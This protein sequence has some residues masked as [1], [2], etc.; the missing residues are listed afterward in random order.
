MALW[1]IDGAHAQ[2]NFSARH[3]MVTT[4]RGTFGK[5]S[6]K[7][8]FDPANPSAASVEAVIEPREP[9]TTNATVT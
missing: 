2:A 5:V 4:V 3:M 1:N 6:G 9:V 7:I 8:E